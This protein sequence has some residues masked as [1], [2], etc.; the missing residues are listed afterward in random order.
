MDDD[1]VERL[2][3][4]FCELLGAPVMH[5]DD[6]A[7]RAARGDPML[8][9]EATRRAFADWIAAEADA[10]PVLLVLEDLHWGDLPSVRFV[11][12]ALN[13][14]DL[15]LVRADYILP[16]SGGGGLK[17]GSGVNKRPAPDPGLDREA[18]VKEGEFIRDL[19]GPPIARTSEYRVVDTVSCVYTFTADQRF[20][21]TT[22]GKCIVVSACSGHGYKF[23]AAIGRRVA[24]SVETGDGERLKRW[25]LGEAV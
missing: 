12:A 10:Q 6:P 4:F 8:L 3:L 9:G 21:A 2:W 25:L 16:P 5:S 7:L 23:G 13:L 11:E 19:F 17:F 22:V 14:L 20:H 1:D 24:D 18:G 15:M